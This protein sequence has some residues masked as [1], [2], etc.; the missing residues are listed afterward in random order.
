VANDDNFFEI[1][2]DS[3]AVVEAVVVASAMGL[4]LPPNL[5]MSHPTVGELSEALTSGDYGHS[6]TAA[7]GMTAADILADIEPDADFKALIA[8]AALRPV[9]L[10]KTPAHIFITGATGFLG[11]RLLH[12]LL[13][14]TSARIYCLV[15]ASSER[16]ASERLKIA[17]AKHGLEFGD[18]EERVHPI[19]GELETERFGIE[20]ARWD[21]LAERVDTVYHCAAEVN[22]LASYAEMRGANLVGTREVVR[23]MASGRTKVMHYASTLSVFVATDKNSGRLLES[24]DLQNTGY[25]YGGYAQ[26]KWA[27]EMFLRRL[28]GE[29]GPVTYHRFGLVT[30]D[31]VSGRDADNDFLALFVQGIISLGAAPENTEDVSVDITPID[32]AARAMVALSFDAMRTGL[33]DTYHIANSESLSLSRLL[34]C[35]ISEG[36]ELKLLPTI[37]FQKLLLSRVAMLGAVESAAC[38]ALCRIAGD[39]FELFRTMDLFQ[40]TNVVFDMRNTKSILQ[41]LNIVCPPPSDQ[42]IKIYLDHMLTWK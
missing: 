33:F 30:G 5:L 18:A 27:A 16:A 6:L 38:L 10:E 36:V 26:T 24:D 17:M 42:L 39:D 2:G 1:G 41:P 3:F 25:I 22:N 34:N 19:C 28:N 32:F 11:S 14:K 21:D 4:A 40:A 8:S 7:G 20:A 31:S 35:I 29:A 12:E 15:R 13:H 37:E 9:V 23:L